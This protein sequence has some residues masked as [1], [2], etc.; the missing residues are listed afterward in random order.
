[1]EAKRI[2]MFTLLRAGYKKTEIS[3]ELNVSRM[4]IHRVEQ[5][6]KAS[7]SL[8]DQEDLRLQVK[9]EVIKKAFENY[10]CQKITKLAQKKKISVSTVSRMVKKKQRKS[11]IR[12]RKSLLSAAMVQKRLERANMRNRA[13]KF[14]SPTI[15]RFE[16]PR[17]QPVNAHWGKILQNT[18]EQHRWGQGFCEPHMTVDED[19]QE[20]PTSIRACYFY[21]RLPGC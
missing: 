4:A 11:L 19:Q 10:P 3:N 7:E 14:L 18:P 20:L 9:K 6:L 16:T 21:Q 17:F 15:T 2:E 1:M 5:H 12:S 8:K 13:K